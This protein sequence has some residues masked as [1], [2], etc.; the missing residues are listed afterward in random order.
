MANKLIF[1]LFLLLLP[2]C[3]FTIEANHARTGDTN[4][5]MAAEILP[6]T[7]ASKIDTTTTKDISESK[8]LNVFAVSK[9]LSNIK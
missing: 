8:T 4:I 5:K 7:K 2:S 1:G 9:T 6:F 3:S